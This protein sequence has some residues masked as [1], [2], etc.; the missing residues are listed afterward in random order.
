MRIP[1]DWEPV[2]FSYNPKEGRLE[3]ANRRGHMARFAWLQCKSAPD[4]RKIMEEFQKS[5]LKVA[6]KALLKSFSG[7]VF[8]DAGRFKV[9]IHQDGRPFQAA[10]FHQDIKTLS[11]WTFP[12]FSESSLSELTPVLESFQE[13]VSKWREWAIWGLDFRLPEDFLPISVQPLPANVSIAFESPRKH[14]ADFHRWGLPAALLNG[15]SLEEFYRKFL[16]AGKFRLDDISAGEIKGFPCAKA[17]FS[18]RGEFDM[19]YLYGRAWQGDGLCWLEEDAMRLNA[20]EQ[21]HSRKSPALEL[22]DVLPRLN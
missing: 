21:V 4:I 16:R 2:A 5:S 20:F 10:L 7:L 22:R 8:K 15:N 13:N 6:D 18:K 3:F 14:R 12:D 1:S 17:T 11:I 9:G 19:D